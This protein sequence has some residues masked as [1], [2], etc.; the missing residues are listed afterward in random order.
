MK[1]KTFIS[2]L[3]IAILVVLFDYYCPFK[4]FFHRPCIGCGLTRALV[5]LLQGNFS[6]AFNLNPLIY[7]VLLWVTL[8]ILSNYF[9]S[10]RYLLNQPMFYGVF[11]I[12]ALI[13]W[14]YLI[15]VY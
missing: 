7:L 10:I 6:L 2:L 13:R 3:G 11:I 4:Y 1:L 8:L 9:N 5:A 14:L 15:I 12:I